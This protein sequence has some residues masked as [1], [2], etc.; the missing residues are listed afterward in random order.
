CLFVVGLSGG[1]SGISVR[2]AGKRGEWGC[3]ELAGKAGWDE[4]WTI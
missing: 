1:G 4:Q 3:G 2:V